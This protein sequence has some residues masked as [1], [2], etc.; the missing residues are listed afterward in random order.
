MDWE[1]EH[2]AGSRRVVVLETGA[3]SRPQ[4]RG[5]DHGPGLRR[6]AKGIVGY[7]QDP[8][9]HREP[10]AGAAHL[11]SPG[12]GDRAGDDR[13]VRGRRD[14]GPRRREHPRPGRVRGPAD[15]AAG[16]E[17]DV[18]PG[19]ARRVQARVGAA[20]HRGAA[21]LRLR[22]PGS[23]G[24]AAGADHGQARGEPDHGGRRGPGADHGSAFAADPGLLRH[25]VRP[26]VR[27]AGDD[28]VLPAQA[29]ARPR[30]RGARHRLRE[31][32]ARVRQAPGGGTGPRRQA[33]SQAPT[34][35]R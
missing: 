31:D 23:Q 17:H 1:P 14:P 15:D 2:G 24:P 8:H 28:R 16:G 7:A 33:P 12:R 10:R 25:P 21:V 3:A 35:S 5:P 30:R 34:R 4:C 11:R 6:V 22:A 9:R 27:R 13:A 32:G 20:R 18:A 19:H 26:P 29:A